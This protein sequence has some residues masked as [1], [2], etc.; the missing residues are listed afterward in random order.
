MTDEKKVKKVAKKEMPRALALKT[1]FTSEGK[2][3]KGQFFSCSE[4]EMAAFKKVK[5]V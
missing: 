1:L 3:K 5:A 4:K 2:V